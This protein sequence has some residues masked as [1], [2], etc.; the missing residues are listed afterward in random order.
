MRLQCL[1]QLGPGELACLALAG[2]GESIIFLSDDMA[3]RLAAG[4]FSVQVHGTVGLIIR[5]IRLGL[6]SRSE[7]VQIMESIP[8]ATTPHLA[9]SLMRKVVSRIRNER[10]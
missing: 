3:A 5:S 6:V 4:G 1:F 8:T 9:R 7:A 10:D 2:R